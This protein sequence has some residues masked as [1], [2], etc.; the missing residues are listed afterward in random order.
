[1]TARAKEK[2]A[3]SSA[4]AGEQLELPGFVRVSRSNRARARA[5]PDAFPEVSNRQLLKDLEDP[6]LDAQEDDLP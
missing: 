2:T 5:R 3:S 4:V 1:M 6:T